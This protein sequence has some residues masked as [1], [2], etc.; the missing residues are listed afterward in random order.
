MES[1][2]LH[3]GDNLGPCLQYPCYHALLLLFFAACCAS[4][5]MCSLRMSW[6]TRTEA[7]PPL[8]LL[9]CVQCRC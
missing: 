7:G 6:Q 5:A 9:L 2:C 3:V 4:Q 1:S 8:P